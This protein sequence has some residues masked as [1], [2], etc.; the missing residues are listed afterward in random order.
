[1]CKKVTIYL[2]MRMKE[3]RR[4]KVLAGGRLC[5]FILCE[6]K[7]LICFCVHKSALL[8]RWQTLFHFIRENGSTVIGS[9]LSKPYCIYCLYSSLNIARMIKGRRIR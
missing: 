8:H 7:N 4:F 9:N 6:V 1:M 2:G 5:I 3:L